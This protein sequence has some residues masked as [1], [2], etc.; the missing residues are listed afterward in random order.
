MSH[1]H[2]LRRLIARSVSLLPPRFIRAAGGLQFRL[3]LVGPLIGLAGRKLVAGQGRIRHGVGAGLLFD[4]TGGFP[5][6]LLGTSG[7][8]E[9]EALASHLKPGGVFY[10]IGANVG[11][12]ST[13]AARLVGPEG[14]VY[15]FEP[16]PVS[17]RAARLNA[18][19]NGFSH[20]EVIEAAVSDREGWASLKAGESSA[21]CRVEGG[22]GPVRLISL[23]SY[24]AASAMRPPDVVMIDVE[25]AEVEVL[26]GMA[27]TIRLH[28]PVVLC[29]VHWLVEEFGRVRADIFDPLGYTAQTLTGEPLP[30]VPRH[31]NAIML[32]P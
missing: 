23:D 32:P 7:P 28:R 6:Y 27:E 19:R 10:D 3:P 9:Q 18:E 15:A 25:G 29:E 20:V 17:A 1:R 14:R 26:R 11:F 24:A 4:A 2:P 13:I 21:T 12:F 5:G 30:A 16:S 22:G 31:Y 8:L